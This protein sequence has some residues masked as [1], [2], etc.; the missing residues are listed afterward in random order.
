V[1]SWRR[2]LF[3]ISSLTSALSADALLKLDAA[4]TMKIDFVFLCE[5]DYEAGTGESN[6]SNNLKRLALS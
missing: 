2:I 1:S 5:L 3:K 6:E 4:A